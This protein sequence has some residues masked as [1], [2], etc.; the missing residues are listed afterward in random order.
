MC[1]EDQSSCTGESHHCTGAGYLLTAISLVLS[2]DAF[3][4]S[5]GM[6]QESIHATGPRTCLRPVPGGTSAQLETQP[7]NFRGVI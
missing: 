3:M 6:K 2:K 5:S 1:F 4:G 7:T